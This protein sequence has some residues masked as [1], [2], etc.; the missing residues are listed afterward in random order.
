MDI[1]SDWLFT[2]GTT[3]LVKLFFKRKTMHA[4]E[5]CTQI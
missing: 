3:I 5:L 1:G 2:F 4:I